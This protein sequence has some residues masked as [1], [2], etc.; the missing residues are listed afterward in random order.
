MDFICYVFIVGFWFTAGASAC[1]AICAILV[2]IVLKM[3]TNWDYKKYRK[4]R[5]DV[6]SK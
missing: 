1:L 4:E 5:K 6:T 2:G 3:L